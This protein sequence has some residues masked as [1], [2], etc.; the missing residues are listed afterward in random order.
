MV[1]YDGKAAEYAG[2]LVRRTAIGLWEVAYDDGDTETDVQPAMIRPHPAVAAK[3]PAIPSE[4]AMPSPTGSAPA[5]ADV[6]GRAA[7]SAASVGVDADEATAAAVRLTAE[8]D[9]AVVAVT[10]TVPQRFA[11]SRDRFVSRPPVDGSEVATP[12]PSS[13]GRGGSCCPLRSSS[14][15][16]RSRDTRL[17]VRPHLQRPRAWRGSAAPHGPW[18]A[19]GDGS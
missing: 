11:S 18:L 10:P 1:R 5:A 13:T 7:A 16:R 19:M 4:P 17:E 6:A 15:R 9:A 12:V 3:G 14:R 2:T 8:E